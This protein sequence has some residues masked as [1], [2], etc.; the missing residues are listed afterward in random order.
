MNISQALKVKNRL[1]GE[2]AALKIRLSLNNRWVVGNIAAYDNKEVFDEYLKKM[3]DLI[4]LKSSIT[5]ASLPVA[6]IIYRMGELKSLV[7]MLR[8]LNCNGGI[9]TDRYGS[10]T[11]LSYNVSMKQKDRDATVQETEQEISSLQDEL[12]I[13]NG[14]TEI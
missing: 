7:V 1:V 11:P 4:K 9:E 2:L 3:G 14:K 8:S 13:F 6:I 12:D 10:G 5:A